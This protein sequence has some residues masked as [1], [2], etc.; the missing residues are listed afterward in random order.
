MQT[1][2]QI[3]DNLPAG[4]DR[5]IDRNEIAAPVMD[6]RKQP[7]KQLPVTADPAM[8][9]LLVSVKVAG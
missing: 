5:Q 7:E 8:L 2:P 4:Q 1:A 3:V 6:A 9:P